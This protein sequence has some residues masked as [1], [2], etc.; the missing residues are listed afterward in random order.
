[1]LDA[2]AEYKNRYTRHMLLD[3]NVLH[4]VHTIPASLFTVATCDSVWFEYVQSV[5]FVIYNL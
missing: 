3:F 1:M 5:Q 4:C 2:V